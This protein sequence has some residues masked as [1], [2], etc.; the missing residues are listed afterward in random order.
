MAPSKTRTDVLVSLASQLFTKL[1]GYLVLLLMIRHLTKT[2]MGEFFFLVSLGAL[3]VMLTDLGSKTYL[4]RETALHPAEALRVFERVLSFRMTAFLLYLALLGLALAST[5]PG[6]GVLALLVAS[7]LVVEEAYFTFAGLFLG[8]QRVAYDAWCSA[9]TRVLLLAL[10]AA[11]VRLGAGLGV[12]VG[13]FVVSGVV[14]VALAAALTA[15]AWKRLAVVPRDAFPFFLLAVLQLVHFK[16]GTVMLGLIEGYAAVATYEAGYKFLEASTFFI[17]PVGTIFF[18]LWSDLAGR[19]RWEELRASAL[20][21]LAVVAAIGAALALG[22]WLAAGWLAPAVLGRR[23]A[24]SAPVI[25]TLFYGVP[26]VFIGSVGLQVSNAIRAE[27]RIVEIMLLGAVLN[28][29]LNL[30]LIPRWAAIGAAWA[31]V[32][33][34]A[35]LAGLVLAVARRRLR[36]VRRAQLEAGAGSGGA[37]QGAG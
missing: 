15:F 34:E 33:S 6:A 1:T 26:L 36:G 14:R 30:V 21:V 20:K 32:A 16:I 4:T 12:L 7:Y 9:T 13:C 35:V 28:V 8:L 27:R 37:R 2:E 22:A 29:G 24:D 10:V 11:A 23:Y 31:T 18:P 19:E 5:R 25:V 3:A 17:Y